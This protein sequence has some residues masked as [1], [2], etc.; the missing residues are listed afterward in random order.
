MRRSTG[1][2]APLHRGT[3]SRKSSSLKW[4]FL[5]VLLVHVGN[6]TNADFFAC[7]LCE[8]RVPARVVT[9]NKDPYAYTTAIGAV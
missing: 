5:H 2:R 3:F 8:H 6:L 4:L 7:H 9:E 1:D